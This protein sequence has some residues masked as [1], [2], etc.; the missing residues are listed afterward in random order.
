MQPPRRSRAEAAAIAH[1][2]SSDILGVMPKTTR[3]RTPRDSRG[4]FGP[5]GPGNPRV[6]RIAEHQAAIAEPVEPRMIQ[7]LMKKLVK[8]GLKG[9]VQAAKVVLERVA[10]KPAWEQPSSGFDLPPIEA[11]SDILPAFA[12]LL[13]AAAAGKSARTTPRACRTRSN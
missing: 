9:E 4:R 10:G 13:A 12:R 11:T 5:G 8:Q 2:V 6:R 7:A 3:R 1:A